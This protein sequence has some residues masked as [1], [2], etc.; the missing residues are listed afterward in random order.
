MSRRQRDK[1]GPTPCINVCS[2]EEDTGLC[3]GCFRTL[4]EVARW[5]HMNDDERRAV[6]AILPSRNPRAAGPETD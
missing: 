6:M 2:V 1:N 3:R 5:P 4:E